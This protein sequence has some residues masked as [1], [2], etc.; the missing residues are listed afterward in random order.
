MEKSCNIERV[1]KK[2]VW[3]GKTMVALSGGSKC[4]KKKTN[5]NNILAS[6]MWPTKKG[7][8]AQN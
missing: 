5:K 1:M 4:T 3:W 2:K 7:W 6:N 8:K